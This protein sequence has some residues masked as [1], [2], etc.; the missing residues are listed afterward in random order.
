M[1]NVLIISEAFAP[2]NVIASVRFTKVVKYLAR[3]GEYRFWVICIG[4]E[5]HAIKDELLQRD[6]EEVA[7]YVTVLP[8]HVDKKLLKTIK[9][10]FSGGRRKTVT[11][12]STASGEKKDLYYAIEKNLVFCGQKG[13]VGIFKRLLGRIL[14]AVSEIYDL[15][16]EAAFAR[17]G[18]KLSRLIPVDD[19]E[20]MISTYGEV[21]SL[22]LALKFRNMMKGIKWIVDYRDAIM[23]ASG[24]KKKY[25]VHVLAKADK[26]ADFITGATESCTGSGKYM[27]K[28][29]VITNGFDVEDINGFQQHTGNPKLQIVYTGNLYAGKRD[30]TILFRIISELESE[31]LLSSENISVLYAGGQF[32]ILKDQA[33][34]C[35]LTK[36]LINEGMLPRKKALELQYQAD[37]LCC[38]TWG[39]AGYENVLPGKTLEFF[40]MNVPVFSIVT[41]TKTDS[42]VKRIT[43]NAKL[44]Y[45]YEEAGGYNNFIEAKQWFLERYTEF[46]K[47]GYIESHSD[48]T[49]LEEYSSANMA[50]KFKQFIDT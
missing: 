27:E 46:I 19:I 11:K 41:G 6:L 4:A 22:L 37:I 25:L 43:Q 29:H 13:L 5:K 33:K 24:L 48:K 15:T 2:K 36:V 17:K 21:G 31:G 44:G 32:H 18:I 30:M 35:N 34:A 39:E 38:L 42:I 14:L 28:F 12:K 49:V 20:V 10:L 50:E 8:V 40:M 9:T 3:T 26:K 23:A 1:K 7:E 45:C 47:N 16:Y